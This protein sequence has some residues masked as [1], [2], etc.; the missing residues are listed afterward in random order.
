MSTTEIIKKLALGLFPWLIFWIMYGWH[1]KK[2]I[3]YENLKPVLI[4]LLSVT[5]L[6]VIFFIIRKRID[7]EI[8]MYEISIPY[9]YLFNTVISRYLLF[10]KITKE[11]NLHHLEYPYNPT[12]SLA[13]VLWM[14]LSKE[15]EGKNFSILELIFSMW[16]I[17]GLWPWLILW[18]KITNVLAGS[19]D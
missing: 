13:G 12:I 18:F 11:Y 9:I 6:P 8:W 3:R 1:T 14:Y 5:M 2:I 4:V 17:L 7:Y 10:N 15:D 16:I 19:V